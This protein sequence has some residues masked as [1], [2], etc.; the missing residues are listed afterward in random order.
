MALLTGHSAEKPKA[1]GWGWGVKMEGREEEEE[2]EGVK[3]E[4]VQTGGKADTLANT[5]RNGF[6]EAERVILVQGE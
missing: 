2:E 6:L 4:T 1:V 3:S 5:R